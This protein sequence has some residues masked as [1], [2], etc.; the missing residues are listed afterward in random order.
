[1][2]KETMMKYSEVPEL[3]K[4]TP[5]SINNVYKPIDNTEWTSSFWTGMLWLAYDI[6]GDLKYKSAA[7]IQ[8]ESYKKR[9]DDRICTDTHDLGFLYTLSCV[10]SYKLTG[11]ESAKDT[12]IAAAKILATRYFEKAGII[13]AWGD[14]NDPAQRGRMIIDCLMNLPLLYWAS[15]V[16]GDNRFYEIAKI[17]A[18]QSAKH[19][20]REDASCYHTYYMD[21]ETGLPK[22]GKTQQGYSDESCWARGQAWAIYGFILSYIYTKDKLYLE[23][24]VI[25][26]DYFLNRLPK[27]FVCYWDLTFTDG[28]EERD[29]SA[30]AIACSGLMELAKHIP[31]ND[32]KKSAYINASLAILNSLIKEFTSENTALSNGVLLHSVYSKPANEGVDECTI[33]GDYFYFESLVRLYKDWILYW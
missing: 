21:V 6:T 4:E 19:L 22:Y 31:D 14:L 12:A 9:L 29:S 8:I 32:E 25:T 20:I 13:Q 16:T 15:Q 26:A 2:W 24:S 28:S 3:K 23:R 33:W 27:D 1:M 5:A 17:H 7:D 10:A 18:G 11:D 30:A